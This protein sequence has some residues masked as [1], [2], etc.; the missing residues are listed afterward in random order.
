MVVLETN[1]APVLAAL[2]DRTVHA[3]ALIQFTNAATDADLPANNLTFNLGV[4]APPA[5]TVDSTNGIF[6]WLTGADDAGT[7]NNI[8]IAVTDDGAPALSA[9][10]T[11]TAT[12]VSRPLIYSIEATNSIVTLMWSAIDGQGYRLQTN[13]SLAAPVWGDAGGDVMAVGTSASASAATD[14]AETYFRVRV[15]P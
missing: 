11:F 4:G 15:L 2:A 13:A 7:T 3:G 14:Q 8:T 12:V 10:R 9:S 1:S 5:A 6:S